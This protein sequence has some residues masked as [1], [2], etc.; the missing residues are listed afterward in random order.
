MARQRTAPKAPPQ[1]V[2]DKRR[3]MVAS[4]LARGMRQI[5]IVNQLGVEYLMRNGERVKNPSHLINPVTQEPFDKAT[6]NR[7]VQFLR[8]QW[9]ESAAEDAEEMLSRQLAELR[10]ARRVA[11]GRGDMDEV[12]LNMLAEIKL[13]GTARPEKKEIKLNDEQFKAIQSAKDRVRD[14]LAQMMGQVAGQEVVD[15]GDSED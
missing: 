13:T 4:L 8:K 5:E 1:E 14:K 6:I 11:W 7:D 12:R 2:I 15:V 3:E 9:R 10:E